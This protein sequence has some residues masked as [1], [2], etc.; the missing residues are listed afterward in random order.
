MNSGGNTGVYEVSLAAFVSLYCMQLVGPGRTVLHSFQFGCY[1][2]ATSSTPDL[3]LWI[4]SR[5][6]YLAM[7]Q[8][9]GNTDWESV[10]VS[11][12]LI[13]LNSDWLRESRFLIG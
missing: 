10:N 6:G 9:S 3:I 13:G 7:V 5:P 11:D 2:R 1:A 4:L 8:Q 12:P